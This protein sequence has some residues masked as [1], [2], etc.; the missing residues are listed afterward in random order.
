MS[1]EK[2]FLSKIVKNANSSECWYLLCDAGLQFKDFFYFKRKKF[3]AKK[4]SYEY[5]SG[6]VQP[7][8]KVLCKCGNQLCIN[9]QHH[10]TGNGSDQIKMIMDKGWKHKIGWKQSPEVIQKISETHKGKT[11]SQELRE[12]LRQANLG[13]KHSLETRQKISK[14]RTG[15]PVKEAARKKNSRKQARSEELEYKINSRRYFKDKRISRK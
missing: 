7:N 12:R 4:F 8:L 14:N 9:P 15:V 11:I 3:R 5:F 13:K 2:K 10:F 1:A 6:K